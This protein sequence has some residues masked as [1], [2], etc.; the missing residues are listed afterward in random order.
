[1]L[2]YV[3]NNIDNHIRKNFSYGVDFVLIFADNSWFG[4]PIG[5][6]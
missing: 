4:E 5:S 3:T 6:W 2:R 1:M